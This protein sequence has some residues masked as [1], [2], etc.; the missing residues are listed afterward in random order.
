MTHGPFACIITD[1]QRRR[2]MGIHYDYKSTRGDKKLKKQHEREQRRRNKKVRAM[3]QQKTDEN[4]PLTLDMIT[5]PD[6]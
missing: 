4:K 1:N 3:P 2:I 6:K 5:D